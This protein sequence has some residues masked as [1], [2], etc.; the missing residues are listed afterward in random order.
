MIELRSRQD[1]LFWQIGSCFAPQNRAI[2]FWQNAS[3]AT[4]KQYS[5]AIL[6]LEE[7][8]DLD[9]LRDT[10][11]KPTSSLCQSDL[12]SGTKSVT[13]MQVKHGCFFCLFG[14]LH[15]DKSN[16]RAP[17]PHA[18]AVQ[19]YFYAYVFLFGVER[20]S[21]FSFYAKSALCFIWYSNDW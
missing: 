4:V 10:F 3:A 12:N 16:G 9:R 1:F 2:A 18:A 8:G 6:A 14:F 21:E 11:V 15:I 19:R 7:A 13:F 17:F 20:D 5:D